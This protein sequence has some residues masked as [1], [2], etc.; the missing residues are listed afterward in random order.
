MPSSR[1]L[2]AANTAVEGD[3]AASGVFG[4]WGAP[5]VSEDFVTVFGV[6]EGACATVRVRDGCVIDE[7]VFCAGAR[8]V[9]ASTTET[10]TTNLFTIVNSSNLPPKPRDT[11]GGYLAVSHSLC[12]DSQLNS[13]HGRWLRRRIAERSRPIISKTSNID[14]PTDCPVN[15]VRQAL[16]KS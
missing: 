8:A 12:D 4:F 10:T 13:C 3:T 9:L 7:F 6:G 5:S 1:L 11:G 15:M 16:I 2:K 14:G